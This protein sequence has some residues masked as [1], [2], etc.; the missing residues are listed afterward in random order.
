[1]L[2]RDSKSPGSLRLFSADC[3]V[4][5]SG[6]TGN[7]TNQNLFKSHLETFLLLGPNCQCLSLL[8][9]ALTYLRLYQ[10][11]RD[12]RQPSLFALV[13]SHSSSSLLKNH[14]LFRSCGP[15][16]VSESVFRIITT[17]FHLSVH[18]NVLM[19]TPS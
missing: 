2:S 7:K 5:A 18:S 6:K 13:S 4:W 14:P 10:A 8:H 3:S 15:D 12:P 1:M 16:F 17:I 9:V 11:C 19:R